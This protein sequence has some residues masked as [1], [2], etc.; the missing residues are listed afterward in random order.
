MQ[1]ETHREHERQGD[2][3]HETFRSPAEPQMT[4]WLVLLCLAVCVS[5][6]A[7]VAGTAD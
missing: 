3:K 2:E 4:G 7:V 6:A 1:R 5:S